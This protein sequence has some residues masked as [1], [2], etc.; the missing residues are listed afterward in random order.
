[1]AAASAMPRNALNTAH[2]RF[3]KSVRRQG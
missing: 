2:E 1:V 3:F